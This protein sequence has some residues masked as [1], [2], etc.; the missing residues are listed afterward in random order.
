MDPGRGRSG[1]PL[2]IA[3]GVLLAVIIAALFL[4]LM[5]CP[6]CVGPNGAKVERGPFDV[7]FCFCDGK[8][9][10]LVH[11]WK[12]RHDLQKP[13]PPTPRFWSG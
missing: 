10:S 1:L 8:K 4:P 12:L 2:A 9:I 7:R 13:R 3:G 5:D 6:A 11:Y